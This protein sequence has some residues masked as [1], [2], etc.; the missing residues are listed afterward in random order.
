MVVFHVEVGE[1]VVTT[2]TSAFVPRSCPRHGGAPSGTDER[3]VGSL[4]QEDGL[5]C[6]S[7]LAWPSRRMQGDGK[8]D[9]GL[10]VSGGF[11]Q[12]GTIVL[13]MEGDG[14]GSGGVPGLSPADEA[15]KEMVLRATSEVFK[16]RWRD[17]AA[18]V[19]GWLVSSC[20][21][22]QRWFGDGGV[23]WRASVQW[24]GS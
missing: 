4:V 23:W 12:H 24:I 9:T 10:M 22:L 16:A 2:L 19:L 15:T 5:V 20:F 18:P 8:S 6:C 13:A 1:V 11:I 14:S 7:V 21:I 17:D 3:L